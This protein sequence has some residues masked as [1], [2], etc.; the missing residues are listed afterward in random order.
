MRRK[1]RQMSNLVSFPHTH[2]ETLMLLVVLGDMFTTYVITLTHPTTWKCFSS[3]L[4]ERQ[5]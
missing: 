5:C 2:Y 1:D 4:Q 3:R